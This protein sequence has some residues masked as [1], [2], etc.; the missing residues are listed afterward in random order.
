MRLNSAY[1]FNLKRLTAEDICEAARN[2]YPDEFFS[3]LGGDAKKRLI[4]ELVLVPAIYGRQ[5]ALV[6]AHLLPVDPRVLGS[7]H[8]HPSGSAR[9]SAGDLNSFV[10]FGGIHLIICKP[11]NIEN[12]RA[13]DVA[14]NEIR[15]EIVKRTGK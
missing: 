4:D 12:M 11:F 7:V 13:F 9:P 8:S 6:K 1:A 10:H 5:H 3:L 14:G 2:T 15:F